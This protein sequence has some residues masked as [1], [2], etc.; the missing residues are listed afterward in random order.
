MN[1]NLKPP[2]A[3]VG[4]K[5]KIRNEIIPLIP[6]HEIYVEPFVGSGAIFF[7]K[8]KAKVNILNDLNKDVIKRLK[9][10]KSA[11]TD[12]TTYNQNLNTITKIKNF[13]NK[14]SET[15]QDKLLMEHIKTNNGFNGML[16]DNVKK[17][18]RSLI[19]YMHFNI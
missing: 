3:R 13:Y 6:E 14:H 1:S 15:K 7:N 16:A 4:N 18:I 5:F 8:E 12:L 17:Y 10:V 2:F 9:M 19:H 11:P